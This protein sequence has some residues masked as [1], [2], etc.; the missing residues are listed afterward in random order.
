MKYEYFSPDARELRPVGPGGRR[1]LFKGGSSTS[2]TASQTTNQDNR[3]ANDSGLVA[4]GGSL[5]VQDKRQDNSFSLSNSDSS[6]RNSNNS[7]TDNSTRDS[8][9]STTITV[10][11]GG[12]VKAA[13]DAATGGYKSLLASTDNSIA[14]LTASMAD[15]T[16]TGSEN[17]KELLSSTDTSIAKAYGG[18]NSLVS[19]ADKLFSETANTNTAMASGFT[20]A[21]G[22]AYDNAKAAA[23]GSIDNRT[24]MVLG[25]AGAVAAVAIL[26]R[27][28]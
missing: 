16:R 28:R 8:G 1:L 13:L 15:V 20:D 12:A 3:I 27:K 24:I 4:T 11:D 6:V 10:T 23:T 7:S 17:Y 25:V 19:L 21:V 2:S 5:L 18:V 22:K 9:N 14:R 26:G